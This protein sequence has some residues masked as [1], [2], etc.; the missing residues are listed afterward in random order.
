MGIG[1]DWWELEL[2]ESLQ[3]V[4]E[5]LYTTVFPATPQIWLGL[6]MFLELSGGCQRQLVSARGEWW[7]PELTGGCQSLVVGVR[8]E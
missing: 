5:L 4:P 1:T 3:W 2:N 6:H 7:E 8:A